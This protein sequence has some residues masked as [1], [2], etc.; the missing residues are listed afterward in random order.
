M[1][2]P[3]YRRPKKRHYYDRDVCKYHLAGF[4]PY[5]EFRRTKNDVGECPSVHDEEA[6]A[7]WDALNERE[8]DRTGYEADLVRWLDRFLSDLRKRKQSN[9]ARLKAVEQPLFLHE[10]QAKLDAMSAQMKELL[11]RAEK[12]GE[13]GDVDG[14][15]AAT[16]E[17]ERIKV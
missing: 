12:L 10:D 4:C 3:L 9:S 8:K 14:A 13:E 15:L 2:S 11:A 7:E 16:T 17:V 5:E 1:L 6:K